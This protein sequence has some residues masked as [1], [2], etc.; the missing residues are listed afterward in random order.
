MS[1]GELLVF[2]LISAPHEG[3]IVCV[4]WGPNGMTVVTICWAASIG[5]WGVKGCAALTPL[6]ALTI[7]ILINLARMLQL[8]RLTLCIAGW[9]RLWWHKSIGW[10]VVLAHFVVCLFSEPTMKH[11]E[12]AREL[13]DKWVYFTTGMQWNYDSM[14]DKSWR[15]L[16]TFVC[17]SQWEQWITHDVFAWVFYWVFNQALMDKCKLIKRDWEVTDCQQCLVEW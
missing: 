11:V 9:S 6:T 2:V 16:V 10:R 5:C 12:S 14:L 15:R 4:A 17:D 1:P 3:Q 13:R 7:K 8:N